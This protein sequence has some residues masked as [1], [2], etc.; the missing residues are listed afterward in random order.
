MQY[1]LG[2]VSV[3]FRDKTPEEILFAMKKCGLR[4]IEWGSDVHVPPEKAEEI[5]ALGKEFGIICSSYGTYF[6]IG[7][8]P[9][10]ELEKYIN[11]AKILGTDI[12]RLWCGDKNS[13]D[14][15]QTEKEALFSACKAAAKLAEKHGVNLCMECH[16]YTYTNTKESAAEL[17]AAVDSEYFRMYWQPNQYVTREENLA[18]ARLLSSKTDHLHVFNWKG[19][20][21]FPLAGA[22]ELWR[23]YLSCFR[24][25]R[26]LLLEFMPDGKIESLETEAES[27]KEIV[28]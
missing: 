18:Y 5:A 16:N 17:M 24:G 3:S 1:R 14:Y 13:Q 2:L 19:D 25:E 8:T 27:L 9:T 22:K 23:E 7:V 11:A 12:L 15:S 28:K 21:K 4:Y 26:T 20:E 6:R 10:E